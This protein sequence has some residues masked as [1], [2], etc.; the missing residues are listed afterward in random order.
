[1]HPPA[2]LRVILLTAF[3]LASPRGAAQDPVYVADG[4]IISGQLVETA[5]PDEVRIEVADQGEVRLRSVE[6][7]AIE[8]ERPAEAIFVV[9]ESDPDRLLAAADRFTRSGDLALAAAL[10]EE[11][12]PATGEDPDTHR[13]RKL[14][15]AQAHYDRGMMC[16]F[17]IIELYPDRE[18]DLEKKMTSVQASLSITRKMTVPDREDAPGG[19]GELPADD[20]EDPGEGEA[21][22]REPGEAEE[23]RAGGQ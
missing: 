1:M 10:G 16:L 5:S 13:A 20:T 22:P 19:T 15:D 12:T 7:V 21:T 18:P 6:V 3:L 8:R 9:T 4:R 2:P 23:A 17:R 14:K 11:G